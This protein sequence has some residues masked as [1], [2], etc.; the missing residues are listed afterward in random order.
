[1][2]GA[3][4]LEG[5]YVL[6]ATSRPDL[7]DPALLRPGRL[8]KSLLCSMPT[9]EERHDILR[10]VSRA[11][12]L[13]GD[14]CF[15]EVAQ[16]TEGFTGADL[17]ALIYSAHLEVVHESINAKT[18]IE[19][20]RKE[21]YSTKDSGHKLHWTEI[22]PHPHDSSKITEGAVRSRAEQ[23]AITKRIEEVL[24]NTTAEKSL[25]GELGHNRPSAPSPPQVRFAVALGNV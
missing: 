8:D 22:Q 7:I 3:E 2:D 25:T 17:Q 16:L 9:V 6:A 4:G 21:G 18:N 1:M 19:E 13:D 11:L 10:A 23:E 15:E 12:P 24:E 5:V 20:K 14:L